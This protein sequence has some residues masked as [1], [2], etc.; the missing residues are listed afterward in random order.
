MHILL[1]LTG[2]Q[3]AFCVQR[4]QLPHKRAPGCLLFVFKDGSYLTHKRAPGCPL[5]V[6]KDGSYLTT[7]H[8]VACSLHSKMAANSQESTWLP[9]FCIQRWQLPDNRAPGCLLF[10]F[11]DGLCVRLDWR[12]TDI[13]V[14]VSGLEHPR[15]QLKLEL[16]IHSLKCWGAASLLQISVPFATQETN[17]QPSHPV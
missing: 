8:L 7:E 1:S 6:F 3:P 13:M 11:Q 16:K 10:A 12:Q 9:A 5:F 15:L 14:T 4:W 17:C 2:N